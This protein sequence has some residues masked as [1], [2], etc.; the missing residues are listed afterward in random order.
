VDIKFIMVILAKVKKLTSFYQSI[1]RIPLQQ[2][3]ARDHGRLIRAG[4]KSLWS[5]LGKRDYIEALEDIPDRKSGGFDGQKLL[6]SCNFATGY[7][8]RGIYVTTTPA[9]ELVKLVAVVKGSPETDFFDPFSPLKLRRMVNVV[10]TLE[11][12]L[13]ILLQNWLRKLYV[14]C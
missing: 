3:G 7:Q 9:G 6:R 14:G 10:C 2:F 13:D 1:G 12:L 4:V 8:V 5:V 11:M